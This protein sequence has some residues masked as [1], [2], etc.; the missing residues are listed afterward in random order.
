MNGSPF[1]VNYLENDKAYADI[2]FTIQD[3]YLLYNDSK[4]DITFTVNDFICKNLDEW[5]Q[6]GSAMQM[7]GLMGGNSYTII[8]CEITLLDRSTIY[9]SVSNTDGTTT[10]YA[11]AVVFGLPS[12]TVVWTSTGG[13]ITNNSSFETNL[14]W[15]FYVNGEHHNIEIPYPNVSEINGNDIAVYISDM[16]IMQSIDVPAY[17]RVMP[18]TMSYRILY[19]SADKAPTSTNLKEFTEARFGT[20]TI[21]FVPDEFDYEPT[22]QISTSWN[23]AKFIDGSLSIFTTPIFGSFSLGHILLVVIGIA[24]LFAV[25]KI[26]TR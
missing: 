5:Y 19:Q 18:L 24:V 20:D 11:E 7:Y 16:Q 15:G 25:I 1:N 9:N 17:Q 14:E 12:A 3:E 22:E 2:D 8:T 23:F 4:L 26:F 21:I 6:I 10:D 13:G